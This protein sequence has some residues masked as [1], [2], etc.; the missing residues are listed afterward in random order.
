MTL[1]PQP[2]H[3]GRL[4]SRSARVLCGDAA[5]LLLVLA[6]AGGVL[7]LLAGVVGFTARVADRLEERLILGPA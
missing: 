3:T 4:A 1:V 6:L 5:Q 2:V 7:G